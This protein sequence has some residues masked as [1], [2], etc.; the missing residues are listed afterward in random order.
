[1]YTYIYL[2]IYVY[3]ASTTN[4]WCNRCRKRCGR[5]CTIFSG[6]C[7]FP[8]T[9]VGGESFICVLT[10]GVCERMCHDLDVKVVGCVIFM[11]VSTCL[12]LLVYLPVSSYLPTCIYLS[13][14]VAS[15]DTS[16]NLSTSFNLFV[17]LS[18]S[19]DLSEWLIVLHWSIYLPTCMYVSSYLYLWVH[20]SVWLSDIHQIIHLL[21][22]I[23][24]PIYFYVSVGLVAGCVTCI[25]LSI[26]ENIFVCPSNF[27]ASVGLAGW[28]TFIHLS[29]YVYLFIFLFVSMDLSD[30]LIVL[31]SSIYLSTCIYLSTYLYLWIR[32]SGWLCYIYLFIHPLVSICLPICICGSVRVA[33]CITFIHCLPTCI[34]LS[35]YLYLWICWSGWLRYIYLWI[36][37]TFIYVLVFKFI[38]VSVFHLSMYLCHIYLCISIP[39]SVYLSEWLAVLHLSIHLPTCIV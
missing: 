4:V 31:H 18:V 19:M 39:I 16:I 24:L 29:T 26:Y 1:M 12:Y 21:V 10:C 37:V 14:G 25:H 5:Q 11:Y 17:Y 6:E 35:T 32:R 22:S 30:W 20:R 3:I 8:C 28:V 13:I 36:C 15:G 7:W 2:Y 9:F 33:D 38:C 23:C 34:Y 27:Y